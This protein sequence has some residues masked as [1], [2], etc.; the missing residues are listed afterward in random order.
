MVAFL[1]ALGASEYWRTT[2]SEYG[3]EPLGAVTAVDFP[4]PLPSYMSAADTQA[5]VAETIR[6]S[7][8]ISGTTVPWSGWALRPDT[9]F[10]FFIPT[11]NQIELISCSKALGYHNYALITSSGDVAPYAVMGGLDC[12]TA[13]GSWPTSLSMVV[14]HELVEAATD[15]FPGIAPALQRVDND[16]AAL[17]RISGSEI[18]DLCNA[19]PPIVA[20]LE[21]A[22]AALVARIYS[23]AQAAAGKDP[24]V[25]EDPTFGP[26]FQTTIVLLD[27]VKLA[28]IP[29][30]RGVQVSVGQTVT[31]EVRIATSARIDDPIALEPTT[32]VV[33]ATSTQPAELTLT[34]DRD[35]ARNG[36]VVHL[37]IT[38][39]APPPPGAQG[40]Y[41][42]VAGTAA[43]S[44]GTYASVKRTALGFAGPGR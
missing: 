4:K 40:T 2:T 28:G 27:P 33:P 25:P 34:L 42:G 15:P 31:V 8:L 32:S 26:F 3:V 18:G 44:N 12:P 43:I 23:N 16:H 6:A 38:R 19:L 7:G 20:N 24:C 17:D 14:S 35:T 39:N 9:L 10:L 11:Q 41:F 1:S 5:F 13:D 22:S 37:S 29:T 21:G 36:D 30:V